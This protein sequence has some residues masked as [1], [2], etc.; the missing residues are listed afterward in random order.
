MTPNSFYGT[1]RETGSRMEY[2]FTT[3][4]RN[5]KIEALKIRFKEPRCSFLDFADFCRKYQGKHHNCKGCN[6][7]QE[8]GEDSNKLQ[9]NN[10]HFISFV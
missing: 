1:H 8:D 5:G 6:R 4:R 3:F 9:K 2:P 10:E 7:Y